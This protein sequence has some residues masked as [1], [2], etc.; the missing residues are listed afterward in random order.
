MVKSNK[1]LSNIFNQALPLVAA[2]CFS[3]PGSIF[4]QSSKPFD[5]W[6]SN[7]R[8]EAQSLGVRAETIELAFSEITPPVQRIIENDRSQPEIV[9]TFD[10]YLTRRVSNWKIENGRDQIQR[11]TNLLGEISKEFGVQSR[12]I[13][14]IWGMETNFG[15]FPVSESAFNVLATLSFDNRRSEFFRA[16]FMAAVEMLD[17]GFPQYEQMKSS[18][19]GA[20]GQPQFIPTSYLRYAVDFDGDGLRDI[21]NTEA[22][23]FASIANYLKANGWSDDH[24]WGRPVQIPIDR[25]RSLLE[26]G[27][28]EISPPTLCSRYR[29]LSVWRDLQEWQALGVRRADGTNLPSRSIPASLVLADEG[30]GEAYIVYSNFCVLMSYNPALKYAL[31]IGLLS[32]LFD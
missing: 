23:I 6:L 9:Q 4:S 2:L 1:L 24:T 12:F 3:Y 11:H 21:W 16:Q 20:M 10:D 26:S 15:T 14:S 17:S 30:D 13:V 8:S 18:W 32:D 29:S 28:S 19:A 31:S 22:D 25:E 5:Q 27:E 7:L